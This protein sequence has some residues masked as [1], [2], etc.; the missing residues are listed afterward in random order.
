[1]EPRPPSAVSRTVA[2]TGA[3]GFVGRALIPRLVEAG[4]TV[5]RLGRQLATVDAVDGVE[6][7]RFNLDD[8]CPDAG[9]LAGVDTAFYLVHAMGVGRDFADRDRLYA[10]RFAIA[11]RTAGV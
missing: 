6:D 5:R 8:Q 1:M 3:T 4:F 11:A 2:V 9:A 7:R 10:Q